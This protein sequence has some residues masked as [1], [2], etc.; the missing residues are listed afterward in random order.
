MKNDLDVAI[1]IEVHGH[2][3]HHR[4]GHM[5]LIAPDLF[6][7]AK[8]ADFVMGELPEPHTKD[9]SSAPPS[10][11]AIGTA[12]N[13]L[14]ALHAVEG[15]HWEAEVRQFNDDHVVNLRSYRPGPCGANQDGQR[16][17]LTAIGKSLPETICRAA[18]LA[19]AAMKNEARNAETD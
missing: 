18:L 5:R 9:A 19:C 11:L 12:W 10:S 17:P 14:E 3:W 13:A 15:W 7:W 8:E 4:D 2:R 6:G 1:A 16:T